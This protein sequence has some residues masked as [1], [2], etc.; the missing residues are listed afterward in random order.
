M[1]TRTW[2]G[3]GIVLAWGASGCAI[4]TT[5]GA[6]YQPGLD[7][8]RYESFNW[9]QAQ[10]RHTGDARLENNPFFEDALFGALERELAAHGIRRV[11]SD[12][13]LMVH[14][15]L[16]VE[17]H[18]EVFESD[19]TSGYPATDYGEG[20]EVLQYEEGTFIVHFSEAKTHDDLWIGWARG[21]IGR[22][23]TDSDVMQEWID[24]AVGR[25]FELFPASASGEAQ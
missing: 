19:P 18:I 25:M 10:I 15:H 22:A 7:M 14:Y 2:I 6:D 20:T 8:G 9:D 24:D 3:A 12:P 23:L 4:A 11:E 5:A 16:S 13:D 21:D 1:N 17:D